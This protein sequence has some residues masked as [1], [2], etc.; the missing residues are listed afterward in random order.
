MSLILHLIL[1]CSG[2]TIQLVDGEI[3]E[4]KIVGET[5]KTI[6]MQLE[7]GGVIAFDKN[8]VSKVSGRPLSG[9][10][11]PPQPQARR[12]EAD[13]LLPSRGDPPAPVAVS[14]PSEERDAAANPPPTVALGSSPAKGKRIAL[15]LPVDV[16]PGGKVLRMTVPEGFR[17]EQ[18]G[19]E[20][21]CIAVLVE[22]QSAARVT[23]R[24]ERFA[25]DLSAAAAKAR[26]EAA[27]ELRA[28]RTM[29]LGTVTCRLVEWVKKSE[30]PPVEG[31]SLVV[32]DAQVLV[33][34]SASIREDLTAAYHDIFLQ[35]FK[36]LELVGGNAGA[37]PA[38][39]PKDPS[40]GAVPVPPAATVAPGSVPA[41]C[42]F[43]P[44]DGV[45]APPPAGCASSRSPAS[46]PVVPAGEGAPL[47]G[48]GCPSRDG[49]R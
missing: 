11:R 38:A 3:F 4:G 34:V 41:G 49:V 19:C 13:T 35:L 48:A 40:P 16:V 15:P 5:D 36:S 39:A 26:K 28:E 33:V 32:V 9:E 47:S 37:E 30:K 1:L 24:V 44:A 25:G 6:W 8:R 29:V 31:M 45:S 7:K 21:P 14:P 18:Q 2:G 17:L 23:V 12:V 42:S 10:A 22:A 46:S 43:P 27:G 20:P